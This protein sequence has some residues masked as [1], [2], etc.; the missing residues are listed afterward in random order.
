MKACAN[1]R[2]YASGFSVLVSIWWLLKP[3]SYYA[4]PCVSVF[5]LRAQLGLAIQLGYVSTR[6]Y[7]RKRNTDSS[8][9]HLQL[10][11][12]IKCRLAGAVDLHKSLLIISLQP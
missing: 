12:M 8:L 4:T 7:A 5:V 11:F 9:H 2:K 10:S 1:T 3:P 6:C